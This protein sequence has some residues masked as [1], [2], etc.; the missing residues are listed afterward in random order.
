MMRSS[1]H[2]A[3]DARLPPTARRRRPAY[4]AESRC[5]TREAYKN[6]SRFGQEPRPAPR[7]AA[8]FG[9]GARFA[10]GARPSFLAS[11]RIQE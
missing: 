3:Y 2:C 5:R 10:A 6:R 9:A 4:A 8:I 11:S 7:A 1:P